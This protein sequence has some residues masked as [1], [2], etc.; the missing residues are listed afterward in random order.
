[1]VPSIRMFASMPRLPNGKVDRQRL[2]AGVAVSSEGPSR[3]TEPLGPIEG[4]LIA[5][6][7]ELLGHDRIDVDDN[8]FSLGGT[9]LLGM[10]YITR[11]NSVYGLNFGAADLMRSPTVAS[12]GQL[13]ADQLK[14]KGRPDAGYGGRD[15]RRREWQGS[16]GAHCRC[17]APR[18]RSTRLM[19]PPSPTCLTICWKPQRSFGLEPLVR[20]KL[21]HTGQPQWT[22]V[23]C[24]RLG[25]IALVVIPRL[26]SE[27]I[28]CPSAAVRA[29]DAAWGLPLNSAPRTAALTGI[30]PA[31][32]DY[33]RALTAPPA[34][35]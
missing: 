20:R 21:I 28:A 25:T 35:Q 31:A 23:C 12:M 9:S 13:I 5:L 18:D 24:S 3:A 14:G 33:G 16:F 2:A 27:L 4:Q 1:M 17:C 6:L 11:I 15:F 30:I 22:A 34:F 26:G 19:S 8:F 29:G 10:R 7:E 32:T